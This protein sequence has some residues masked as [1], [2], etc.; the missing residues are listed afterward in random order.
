MDLDTLEKLGDSIPS[1]HPHN[2]ASLCSYTTAPCGCPMN[3]DYWRGPGTAKRVRIIVKHNSVCSDH[4][5][6]GIRDNDGFSRS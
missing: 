2:I 1:A 3:L 5:S 4:I 6:P